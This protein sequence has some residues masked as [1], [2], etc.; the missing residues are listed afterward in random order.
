[1]P[2]SPEGLDFL[3]ENKLRNDRE[4]FRE[5]REVYERTL[6]DPLRETVSRLAPVFEEIDPAILCEPK[7]GRCIS[8][9]F[10]DTRFS[11]DKS[12]FRANL[13]CAF[14]RPRAGG[15]AEEKAPAFFFDISPDG[16][17]L[18]CGYYRMSPATRDAVKTLVLSG[19][20]AFRAAQRALEG[21]GFTL[22]GEAYKRTRF[23]DRP[24]SERQ[25]LDRRDLCALEQNTDFP[26]IFSDAL[27]A[28]LEERIRAL[29]PV[30]AFF[31][32]A[33]E[34]RVSHGENLPENGKNVPEF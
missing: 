21:G 31:R 12:I 19:S 13:W 9:I 4:W 22:A 6:L 7:V 34:L 28:Y 29:A 25:W 14:E 2:F 1:M 20:P 26:L 30:Y 27:F 23:A 8:R 33:E 10:R 11:R 17:E 5:H 18:G 16:L 24:A 15:R 32:A 3:I